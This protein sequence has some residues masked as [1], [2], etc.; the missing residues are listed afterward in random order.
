MSGIPVVVVESGGMPVTPVDGDAPLMTV[1]DAGAPITITDNGAPFVVEGLVPPIDW[2]WQ[3]FDLNAEEEGQWVGYS[4]G[5][6]TRPQP[7]FGSIG[8]EPTDV[9]TL[10]A[11]YD[12][13]AS[14]VF[15]AV[16]DG[17]YV[18]ELDGLQVAISGIVMLSFEVELISGNTWVRFTGLEG[19]LEG[20]STYE[21]MFGFDLRPAAVSDL[22]AVA[23]SDTQVQ[24][25]WS[26]SYYSS[27]QQYR[28]DGGPWID[29]DDNTGEQIVGGLDPETEYDFEVR[30]VNAAG[31]A[32]ASNVATAE[33]EEAAP[34]PLTS[35]V[36]IGDSITENA[37]SAPNEWSD[38]NPGVP[39][40]NRSEGGK[41]LEYLEEQIE[42]AIDDDE[43]S[44]IFFA[45]G[46][47]DLA[48]TSN[49]DFVAAY[50]AI[51]ANARALKPDVQIGAMGVLPASA[52]RLGP[53]YADFNTRRNAVNASLRAAVGDWLD[54]YVPIGDYSLFPDAAAD[55]PALSNDG[56]HWTGS[57]ATAYPAM[58]LVH[59]AV[60]DSILAEDTGTTPNAFS[61]VP[62]TN[63]EPTTYYYAEI[64]V[65]GLGMGETATVTGSGDGA[66]RRGHES[67]GTSSFVVMNGDS[68]T[69]RLEASATPVGV[70]NQTITINGVSATFTVTTKSDEEP[71]GLEGTDDVFRIDETTPSPHV[72][73]DVPFPAGRPVLLMYK[74]TT[75]ED[76]T[77]GSEAMTV[78]ANVNQYYILV[79]D[80]EIAAGNYTVSV[81]GDPYNH[82]TEIAPAALT[83]AVGATFTAPA[84]LVYQY[85][86]DGPQTATSDIDLETNGMMMMFA[87][88][89]GGGVS[90]WGNNEEV[91]T[92][93]D[94]FNG[95]TGYF[96]SKSYSSGAPQYSQA[97]FGYSMILA[98]G[99]NP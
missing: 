66:F 81:N 38:A 28:I 68:V 99:V 72:F 37:A 71:V 65:S 27:G 82:I 52:A 95:L 88:A 46:A 53:S 60:L 45:M 13:T 97:A 39:Y 50:Q 32:P 84:T 59:A 80:N 24:L 56:L 8:S 62:Q 91:V 93:T 85:R 55:D 77:V 79:G 89:N 90:N 74:N 14:G 33:T 4:D 25:S 61:F 86:V 49:T 57:A 19:D 34:I 64:I 70:V 7:A 20:D 76:V 36:P 31:N 48:H 17:D 92:Y 9:T 47:N 2:N 63:A 16:F 96:L 18:S 21:V 35:Y 3:G 75:P 29:C 12:D 1:A 78:V 6:A 98:I 69:A 30:G 23:L 40:N 42:P 44:H 10:L 83:D 87:L 22:E 15:L 73:T 11:F 43:A 41:G 58:D 26:P 94:P 51:A 67:F 54:F 5:G